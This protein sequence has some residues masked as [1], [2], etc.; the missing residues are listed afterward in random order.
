MLVELLLGIVWH[1]A[2]RKQTCLALGGD[3]LGEAAAQE[4]CGHT[5]GDHDV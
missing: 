5:G 1:A 4:G 3:S 2:Q